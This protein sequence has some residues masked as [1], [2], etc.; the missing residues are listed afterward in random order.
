MD[1]QRFGAGADTPGQ[2]K[3][4]KRAELLAGLLT[5]PWGCCT[6][7]SELTCMLLLLS[8]G[9]LDDYEADTMQVCD[10][11]YELNFSCL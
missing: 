1:A 4:A 11:A 2:R 6:T 7:L 8:S 5:Q 9:K 10:C 3:L